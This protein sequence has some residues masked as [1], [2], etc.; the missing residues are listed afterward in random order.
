MGNGVSLRLRV[1]LKELRA[2]FPDWWKSSGG[3][4]NRYYLIRDCKSV[5]QN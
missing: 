1:R 5:S 3:M 2:L 4:N